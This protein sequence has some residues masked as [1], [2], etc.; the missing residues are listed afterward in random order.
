MNEI[1]D[2]RHNI[3]RNNYGSGA[4]PTIGDIQNIRSPSSYGGGCGNGRSYNLT[5]GTQKIHGF[6]APTK[7][8]D[9]VYEYDKP[10]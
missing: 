4:A 9:I 3:S 8:A 2:Y 10:F 5:N 6:G 1:I 7:F